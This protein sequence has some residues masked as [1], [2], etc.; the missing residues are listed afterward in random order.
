VGQ[1]IIPL[2][3]S[4]GLGGIVVGLF[5]YLSTRRTTSGRIDTTEA[6]KLWDESNLMRQELRN[7]VVA[8]REL[9]AALGGKVDLLTQQNAELREQN[10]ECR[11]SEALL[12]HRIEDLERSVERRRTRSD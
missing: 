3:G 2:L 6:A 10:A 7:E 4:L 8:S 9:I 12:R 1:W 5:A 11:Q